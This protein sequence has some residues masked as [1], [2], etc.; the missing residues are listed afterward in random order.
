MYPKAHS[1]LWYLLKLTIAVI[2]SFSFA[3]ATNPAPNPSIGFL[4]N[5]GQ[6]PD[7]D[8]YR[9]NA[10]GFSIAFMEDG[11]RFLSSREI[12]SAEE[13]SDITP[14]DEL[15]R[16][17]RE[18]YVWTMRFK[19]CL[20]SIKLHSKEVVARRTNFFLGNDL[21]KW[22]RQA[23]EFANLY[24]ENVWPGIDVHFYLQ[25]SGELKYDF[26]LSPEADLSAIGVVYDGLEGLSVHKDGQLELHHPWHP[27][28][29]AAP[30][31]WKLEDQTP[32]KVRYRISGGNSYGFEVEGELPSGEAWVIDPVVQVWSTFATSSGS[33]VNYARN[34]AHDQQGRL[35]MTGSADGTFPSTPGIY[36]PVNGGA[37]DAF[38]ARFGSNGNTLEYMTY[39]G[40][41]GSELA[42]D[43][44]RTNGNIYFCGYSNSP[45]LPTTNTLGSNPTGGTKPFVACI[46]NDGTNLIYSSFLCDNCQGESKALKTVSNGEVIV[47]GTLFNPGFPTTSGAIVTTFQGGRMGWACRLNSIGNAFIWSTLIGGSGFDY[48]ND[49]AVNA[50]EEPFIVGQTSSNDFPITAGALYSSFSPA[51]NSGYAMHLNAA[52]TAMIGSTFIGTSMNAV[53]VD[54]ASGDAYLAGESGPIGFAATPNAFQAIHAG[55][56]DAVVARLGPAL[57]NMVFG[58]YVGG[59]NNDRVHDIE[60]NQAGE[61]Y[62]S[63]ETK[64]SNFPINSCQLQTAYGGGTSDGFVVHLNPLATDLAF[65]GSAW[66]GGQDV[67][68]KS[69]ELSLRESSAGDTLFSVLTTHSPNFPVTPGAYWTQKNGINDTPVAMKLFVP[70]WELGDTLCDG[71]S[72][73]VLSPPSSSNPLWSTSETSS[74]IWVNQA[75]TYWVTFDYYGCTLVDTFEVEVM[76]TAISVDLGEDT[77]FCAGSVSPVPLTAGSGTDWLWSTGQTSSSISTTSPG[78]YWVQAT[79]S[80]TGCSATDSIAIQETPLPMISLAAGSFCEGDSTLLVADPGNLY[81]GASYVWSNADTNGQTFFSM[82]GQVWVELTDTNGCTN[83]ATST[84]SQLARPQVDLGPD[85]DLCEGDSAILSALTQSIGVDFLW[86]TGATGGT[87]VVHQPGTFTVAVLDT[88]NGCTSSDSIVVNLLLAP[89]ISLPTDTILCDTDIFT[90]DPGPGTFDTYSW[91]DGSGLALL[92]VS[93]PGEYAVTVT[94]S[95]CLDSARSQV[96]FGRHPVVYLGPDLELCRDDQLVLHVPELLNGTVIWFDGEAGWSRLVDAAGTYWATVTN[97]CGMAS[98]TLLVEIGRG[99]A[100]FFLPNVFTPNNNGINDCYKASGRIGDAFHLQV[101][102]R[103]GRLVFETKDINECWE[104]DFRGRPLPEGVYFATVKLRDCFGKQVTK[105]ET[106]TLVR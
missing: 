75:G 39:F 81:P 95:N 93:Q 104:G 12:E 27:V 78:T 57:S 79:D 82:A 18:Y 15:E 50:Q 29:E 5:Q 38:L 60:V 4:Q 17:V 90:L 2:A 43:L 35:Y 88:Q 92:E 59:S 3:G 41:S 14:E 61:I 22:V 7:Q 51:V 1:F 45:N 100:D 84:V 28:L 87:I 73:Q 56:L 89:V 31:A 32:V 99:V 71:D 34:V 85:L 11:L 49:I 24:Y 13:V 83:Q 55:I 63:G 16:E 62:L 97:S 86:N 30:K 103:W 64:S 25:A 98:D 65:G 106:I 76:G 26:I 53:H 47:V 96:D 105:T 44:E 20:E 101:F 70:R 72:V 21:D 58:T 67:E 9:V 46:S 33:W 69:F 68:Y 23:P 74:S 10:S 52:G 36:Q 37:R 6:W 80:F 91:S 77:S 40:G 54:Q 48:A 42:Y 102:D 66:F 19:N 94:K 8:L